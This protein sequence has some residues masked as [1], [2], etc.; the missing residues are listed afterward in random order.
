MKNKKIIVTVVVVLAIIVLGIKGQGLLEKRK[1]EVA[2]EALPNS[3]QISVEVTKA[4]Q[5][6]LK[7]SVSFLAEILSDKSIKLSTKLVGYVEKVMVEEAQKVKKG[8]LL[9]TIDAVELKS[10]IK[11][12]ESTFQAQKI[13]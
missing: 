1:E 12:L 7:D 4:K 2:N 8:D 11:A 13:D 5:G 6:T 10:N 9:V 3:A